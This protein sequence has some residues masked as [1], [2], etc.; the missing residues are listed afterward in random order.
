MS[1][2]FIQKSLFELCSYIE[3][4]KFPILSY[5]IFLIK[6]DHKVVLKT[7]EE[8]YDLR[9][10]VLSLKRQLELAQDKKTNLHLV[11]DKYQYLDF[12]KAFSDNTLVE[13]TEKSVTTIII[14]DID[15]TMKMKTIVK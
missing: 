3:R 13:E 7:L 14:N 12:K 9:K 4:T 8:M 6:I 10:E 2:G 11:L 15:K 1:L 5:L